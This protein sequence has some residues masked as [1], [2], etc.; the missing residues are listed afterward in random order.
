M[1]RASQPKLHHFDSVAELLA[2]CRARFPGA[3]VGTAN[4]DGNFVLRVA[5]DGR[6]HFESLI[7]HFEGEGCYAVETAQQLA[8]QGNAL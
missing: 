4:Q 8:K 7:V 6:R 2:L 3:E 1:K 5:R